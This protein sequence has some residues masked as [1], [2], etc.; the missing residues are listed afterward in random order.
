[1]TLPPRRKMVRPPTGGSEEGRGKPA[2]LKTA[3]MRTPSS[4]AWLSRQINDPWAAKARAQAR[5]V[6]NAADRAARGLV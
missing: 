5:A 2:R 6:A 4:Q 1:M 3:K